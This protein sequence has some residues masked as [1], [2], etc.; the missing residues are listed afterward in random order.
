MSQAPQQLQCVNGLIFH[1]FAAIGSVT[2]EPAKLVPIVDIPSPA[3]G[4]GRALLLDGLDCGLVRF[5]VIDKNGDLV[6]SDSVRVGFE[7]S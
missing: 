1:A 7:V 2:G 6:T 3:T 5:A 4:T